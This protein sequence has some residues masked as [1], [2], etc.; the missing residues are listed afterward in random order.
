[1]ARRTDTNGRELLSNQ[2]GIEVAKRRDGTT[3]A[4]FTSEHRLEATRREYPDVTLDS[5]IGL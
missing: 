1:V 5:I 4:L 3:L 2:R